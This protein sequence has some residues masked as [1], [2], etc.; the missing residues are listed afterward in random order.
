MK[1]ICYLLIFFF[2]YCQMSS[3]QSKSEIDNNYINKMSDY[4]QIKDILIKNKEELSKL[5]KV[6]SEN[7]DII[8]GF[9]LK[10]LETLLSS[11]KDYM[12]ADIGQMKKLWSNKIFEEEKDGYVTFRQD[13]SVEFNIKYYNGGVSDST[14]YHS[15]IY[16]PNSTVKNRCQDLSKLYEIEPY[17]VYR[18]CRTKFN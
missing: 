9:N 6:N 14:Y 5:K 10:G 4:K 3:C 13:S 1:K 7:Q 16:D 11:D 12:K 8:I 15:I 2:A 18:I 17:W